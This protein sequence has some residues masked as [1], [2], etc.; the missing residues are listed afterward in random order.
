M[1]LKVRVGLADKIQCCIGAADFVWSVKKPRAKSM[2]AA[3]SKAAQDS[4]TESSSGSSSSCSSSSSSSSSS[5]REEC[6]HSGE[7]LKARALRAPLSIG[8][9]FAGDSGALDA[10]KGYQALLQASPKTWHMEDQRVTR[11]RHSM[12]EW[13][14]LCNSMSKFFRRGANRTLLAKAYRRHGI[15]S[16]PRIITPLQMRMV[17]Y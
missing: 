4:D 15:H 9:G 14:H 16:C 10:T 7:S 13:A 12:S 5:S 3:K 1:G 2:A 8:P 6:A 17:V 11:L